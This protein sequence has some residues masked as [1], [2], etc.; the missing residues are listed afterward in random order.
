VV[1]LIVRERRAA[2]TKPALDGGRRR[3]LTVSE[4]VDVVCRLTPRC[5]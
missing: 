1:I 5:L 3:G 4:M 2:F